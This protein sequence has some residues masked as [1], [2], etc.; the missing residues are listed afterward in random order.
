FIC[1]PRIGGDGDGIRNQGRD[2]DSGYDFMSVSW[3]WKPACPANE[4]YRES[5]RLCLTRVRCD[6]MMRKRR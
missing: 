6:K 3:K 5:D 1:V 4:S 2:C